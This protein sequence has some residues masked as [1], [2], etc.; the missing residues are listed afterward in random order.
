[1]MGSLTVTLIRKMK[2]KAILVLAISIGSIVM[3]ACMSERKKLSDCHKIVAKSTIR[4]SYVCKRIRDAALYTFVYHYTF[5]AKS[6]SL[7]I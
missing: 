1:M 6:K 3:T 4:T 7:I 2:N 5:A